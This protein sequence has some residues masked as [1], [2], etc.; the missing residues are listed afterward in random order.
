MPEMT[1]PQ[2]ARFGATAGAFS[3]VTNTE[4]DHDRSVTIDRAEKRVL[5]L[6][7]P[8][9]GFPRGSGSA[10]FQFEVHNRTDPA[11][12]STEPLSIKFPKM[13]GNELRLYMSSANSFDAQRGDVFY[14]FVRGTDPYPHVGFMPYAQWQA[15]ASPLP[16]D[17]DE[18]YQALVFAEIGKAASPTTVLRIPRNLKA[19]VTAIESA[20]FLCEVDTGHKTFSCSAT[21][22]PYVEAHHLMPLSAQH[23]LG[24]GKNLDVP[25]N[26][27][28][29]CPNCHRRFHH[30]EKASR[31]VLLMQ[32]YEQRK[33]A[34]ETAGLDFGPSD[35]LRA[36]GLV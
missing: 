4:A 27:V 32:I 34:W 3:V 30:E 33:D 35:L 23:S 25:E 26:I 36:Y 7:Y 17:E 5:E 11:R 22:Q 24:A 8:I 16:D 19:A 29:L 10:R 20:G 15:G 2:R 14:I 6:L 31:I 9:N 21:G 12:T 13:Q 28:A 1:P 18:K